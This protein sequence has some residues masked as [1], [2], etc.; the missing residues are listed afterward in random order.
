MASTLDRILVGNAELMSR[1]GVFHPQNIEVFRSFGI[2]NIFTLCQL[3]EYWG[4]WAAQANADINNNN[5]FDRRW[6]SID[7]KPS[8]D[9]LEV[10]MTYVDEIHEILNSGE[11][12]YVHW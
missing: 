8:S 7:D 12:A 2:R 10:I 11:K 3:D 5:Y 4:H 9:I 6:I 1:C